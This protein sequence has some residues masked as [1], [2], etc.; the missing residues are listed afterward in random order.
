M[1]SLCYHLG[2]S[3]SVGKGKI[4]WPKGTN[5]PATTPTRVKTPVV[6]RTRKKGPH[7]CHPETTATVNRSVVVV[8]KEPHDQSEFEV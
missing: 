8:D 7:S 5:K 2:H 4:S 1:T 6:L 3:S